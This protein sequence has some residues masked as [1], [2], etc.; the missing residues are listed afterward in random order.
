MFFQSATLD[1]PRRVPLE[2]YQVA[3]KSD[4]YAGAFNSCMA[5]YFDGKINIRACNA[6]HDLNKELFS[7]Q[8]FP[9]KVKPP[10]EQ[11]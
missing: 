4:K 9:K 1:A 11:K 8:G 5:D 3:Q 7:M 10:K 6:M 2:V